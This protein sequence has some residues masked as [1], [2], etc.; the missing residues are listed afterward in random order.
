MVAVVVAVV[1]GVAVGVAVVV[2]VAVGVAVGVVVVVGIAVES[3]DRASLSA[4]GGEMK[5]KFIRIP[6]SDA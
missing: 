1:V 5:T 3:L 6:G 2:V 4:F